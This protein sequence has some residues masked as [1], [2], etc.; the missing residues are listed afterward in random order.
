MLRILM[1]AMLATAGVTSANEAE[2]TM[3]KQ[4]GTLITMNATQLEQLLE[5]LREKQASNP[6]STG[7]APAGAAGDS[8][9]IQFAYKSS[10]FR[11]NRFD[12]P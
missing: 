11:T 3:A 10:K 12:D 1:L 5:L 2:M 4:D 9:L 8:Y 6:V 7:Q